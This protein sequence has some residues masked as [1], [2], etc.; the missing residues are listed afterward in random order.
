MKVLV[1]VFITMAASASASSTMWQNLKRIPVKHPLA[2][3]M[4][5]SLF[6]TSA[7]D[8]L[9]QKVVEQKKEIDWKRNAAF[10]AFGFAY[11]GGVQYAIY[12][13]LFGRLFPNAAKFAAKPLRDKVKDARGMAALV[14]QV[15]LDQAVHH[16]FMYFPVFYATREVVMKDKPDLVGAMNTYRKNMSED[17]AALWKVWVP[18]TFINFAFMPMWTM[19]IPWAAGTSLIWTCILSGKYGLLELQRNCYNFAVIMFSHQH[20]YFR[21]NERR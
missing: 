12:V 17:L 18:T 13:P 4:G 20:R 15:F 16:P 5:F 9:V 14:G 19:R 7:S 8:L 10:A 21:S 11:L 6:K 2:F 1:L 3:G